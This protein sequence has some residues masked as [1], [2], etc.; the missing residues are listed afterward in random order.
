M[1]KA[2]AQR[3]AAELGIILIAPDTSPR[4]L[5]LPGEDESGGSVR[6]QG[7]TSTLVNTL[8]ATTTVWKNTSATSYLS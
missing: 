3:Y 8:G 2:R 7:F 5:N 6:A 1:A 4:G